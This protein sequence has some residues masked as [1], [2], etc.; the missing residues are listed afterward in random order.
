MNRPNDVTKR[1]VFD[2][3]QKENVSKSVILGRRTWVGHACVYVCICVRTSIWRTVLCCHTATW[4]LAVGACM[5][6]IRTITATTRNTRCGVSN[7]W[8]QASP[9]SISRSMSSS[10]KRRRRARPPLRSS[11]RPR[12]V[13]A[14]YRTESK[15]HRRRPWIARCASTGKSTCCL[16][17]AGTSCAARRA[18]R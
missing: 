11:S 14:G 9:C 6:S 12:S 3:R 13:H 8:I 18:P 10:A 2:H 17:R 5:A 4:R 1:L 7:C 16:S 15:P